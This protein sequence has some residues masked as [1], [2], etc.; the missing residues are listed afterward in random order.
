MTQTGKM[1][2]HIKGGITMMYAVI[3]NKYGNGMIKAL[4]MSKDAAAEY[5]ESLPLHDPDAEMITEITCGYIFETVPRDRDTDKRLQYTSRMYLTADD[6]LRSPE[7]RPDIS[8]RFMHY[9]VEV[10]ELCD[11]MAID[12]RRDDDDDMDW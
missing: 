4:F 9:T 3:D 2:A 7:R 6:A 11:S 5:V 12:Y 1:L 8:D 10:V